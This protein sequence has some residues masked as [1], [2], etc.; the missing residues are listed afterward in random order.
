MYIIIFT[1]EPVLFLPLDREDRRAGGPAC[2]QRDD[3]KMAGFSQEG[4]LVA[5]FRGLDVVEQPKDPSG[6][7]NLL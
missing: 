6:N 2:P 3:Q 4:E 7:G 1:N 5:P